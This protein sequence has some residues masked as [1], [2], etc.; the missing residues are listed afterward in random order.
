MEIL[1]Y[2]SFTRTH[3]RLILVHRADIQFSDL[4]ENIR[5]GFAGVEPQKDEIDLSNLSS[6]WWLCPKGVKNLQELG[7]DRFGINRG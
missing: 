2:P 3:E 1:F 6:R 5:D 4:P 7:Y